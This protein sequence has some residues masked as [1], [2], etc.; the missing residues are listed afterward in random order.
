MRVER[1]TADA[2]ALPETQ[3]ED[4]ARNQCGNDSETLKAVLDLLSANKEMGDFLEVPAVDFGRET[5]GRYRAVREIGRGGMSIVYL[6]ERTEADFE[7]TVAIKVLLM[8][9]PGA[10]PQNETKILAALEHPNIAR[11]YDAG[12]TPSGFRYLVMEYVDGVPC[13]AFAKELDERQ[14][15]KLFLEI[16]AGVQHANRSLVIHRDIKP[17]NILV[18]KEG[19]PKLLDFGIAKVLSPEPGIQQTIGIRAYTVDYASP[20]QI[21]GKPVTTATDVYSLGVLLCEL[22]TGA[23]PRT[24]STLPLAEAV[25]RAQNEEVRTIPLKGDLGVIARKALRREPAERYESAS[26]LVQ[27]IERYMNG[28][29]VEAR[30][31]TWWYRTSRFLSRHRYAVASAALALTAL[32][33]ATGTAIWQARL[34]SQRFEQVRGLSK[35]VMFELHDAVRPL[36]GSLPARQLIVKN[37]LQ[38]LDALARDTSADDKLQLEVA[39]G[40]IRLADIEGAGNQAAIGQ[41]GSALTTAER[42]VEI[43]RRV[44]TRSP[45]NARAGETLV[46]GLERISAASTLRGDVD[47]AIRAGREAVEISEKLVAANPADLKLKK[48]AAE[49]L[50]VLADAYSHSKK[51]GE[52]ASPIWKRA[53]TIRQQ[54]A[55]AS[56]D[57]DEERRTL[58]REHNFATAHFLIW[59]N[60]PEAEK[61]ANEAYR[62]SRLRMDAGVTDAIPHLASNLGH[63][64]N[65]AGRRGNRAEAIRLYQEQLEWRRK[66]I[67]RDPQSSQ[68]A[69]GLTATLGRLC[70]WHTEIGKTQQ[71]VAY[72]EEALSRIRTL[73][74]KDPANMQVN[75]ELFFALADLASAYDQGKQKARSCVLLKEAEQRLSDKLKSMPIES[76]PPA[77]V[78]KLVAACGA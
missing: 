41:T 17:G 22:L 29:P 47:Q 50:H 37:S 44:Y 51:E 31:Q 48:E 9:A 30:E 45:K 59:K 27:D 8:Q 73:Y 38:Y 69:L 15:L 34:A 60:L 52:L 56:P 67:E 77:R 53:I 21:L 1:V 14:R 36:P 61:H 65:I 23:R 39:S 49:A 26:A 19:T 57:S 78:L 6:G 12:V 74:A 75:R 64:A 2:L 28:E 66:M 72:G 25:E 18:T 71:A 63:L 46:E 40:Y 58:A 62:I 42:A 4:F 13:T 55:D 32:L 20:E 7:K 16:C 70:F 33:I 11:L 24:L 43:A 35:S 10:I 3:R 5:F 68:A 76:G 54:L